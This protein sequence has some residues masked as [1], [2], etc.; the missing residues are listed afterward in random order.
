MR[1]LLLSLVLFASVVSVVPT[2]EAWLPVCKD[3]SVT[4]PHVTTVWVGVDCYPGV[5]VCQ[6]GQTGYDC[7]RLIEVLP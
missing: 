3:K 5:F 6:P 7:E 4:V 1:A 2:A